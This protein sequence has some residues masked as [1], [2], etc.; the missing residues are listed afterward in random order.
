MNILAGDAGRD[1]IAGNPERNIFRSSFGLDHRIGIAVESIFLVG[2]SLG[3]F[4]DEHRNAIVKLWSEKD[5]NNPRIEGI[6]PGFY[7][8]PVSSKGRIRLVNNT[9]AKVEL[10]RGFQSK[11]DIEAGD[12][13]VTDVVFTQIQDL[14]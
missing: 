9:S 8:P 2:G 1:N 13:S 14:L 7:S 12:D 4:G 3:V 6:P 5:L 11:R 10:S